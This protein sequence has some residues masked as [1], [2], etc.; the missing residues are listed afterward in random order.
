M[1]EIMWNWKAAAWGFTLGGALAAL[2]LVSLWATVRLLPR[3][4]RQG[5]WLLSSGVIRA[6]A[7][8]A[9][10]VWIVVGGWERLIGCLAGFLL[11]RAAGIAK[12]RPRARQVLKEHRDAL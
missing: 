12:M 7:V 9:A 5:L 2:Y 3:V 1:T 8:A 10:F 4:R 6:V 11:V